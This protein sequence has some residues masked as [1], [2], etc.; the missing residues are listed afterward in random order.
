MYVTI[1]LLF[2]NTC[3]VF[4]TIQIFLLKC[5][6]GAH[7]TFILELKITLFTINRI[8]IVCEYPNIIVMCVQCTGTYSGGRLATTLG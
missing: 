3:I 2:S 7:T 8:P 1:I 6:H 5:F 4:S